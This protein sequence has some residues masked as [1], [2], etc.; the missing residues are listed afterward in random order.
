MLNHCVKKAMRYMFGL[1]HILRNNEFLKNE[2]S[3]V[4]YVL[5]INMCKVYIDSDL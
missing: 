3:V 5:F 4:I 1:L 2:T